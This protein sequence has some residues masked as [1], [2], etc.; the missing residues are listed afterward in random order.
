[1]DKNREDPPPPEKL[2]SVKRDGS[3]GGLRENKELYSTFLRTYGKAVIG[4]TFAM[5]AQTRTLSE[6]LPTSLEAF[7]IL[8]YENGYAMWK[9]EAINKLK[10]GRGRDKSGNS[11]EEE[12]E[13]EVNFKFTSGARGSKR[14]E[15]WSDEGLALFN[16]L[17][18]EIEKQRGDEEGTGLAFERDFLAY[19]EREQE[20]ENDENFREV[21]NNWGDRTRYQV[22]E[23]AAV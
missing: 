2:Y 19:D 12:A 3:I 17:F 9:K 11:E 23:R 21:R 20:A 16:R 10:D 8:A 14:C 22:G 15:G 1:M 4:R 7:L 18:D 5:E 13:E 6:F